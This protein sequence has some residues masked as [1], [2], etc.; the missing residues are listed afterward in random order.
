MY[1][2]DEMVRYKY[3]QYVVLTDSTIGQSP[4]T[5]QNDWRL[6]S[7]PHPYLFLRDTARL[8]DLK[9]LMMQESSYIRTYAF[10]ALSF[11]KCDNL[12]P[13]IVDNL[14]DS[15]Q[16]LV[17]TGD[18]GMNAY[19]ADLMLEYEGYRLSK[20]EKKKI[21][22]LI[23]TRYKYLNRGLAALRGNKYQQ[24]NTK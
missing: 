14:D 11:R 21:K 16:M 12:F 24:K 2:Q 13:I 23:R 6:V 20:N 3:R 10:A 7:G 9:N 17:F 15:N 8:E 4:D 5:S 18:V 19:P 1:Y 22:K